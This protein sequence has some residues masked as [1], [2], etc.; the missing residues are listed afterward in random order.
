MTMVLGD[1]QDLYL[2]QR[3]QGNRL[4]YRPTAVAAN[5]RTPGNLLHQGPAADPRGHPRN[6]PWPAAQQRPGRTQEHP[7]AAAAEE[8]LRTAYRSIQQEADKT[9][10]ASSTCRGQDHRAGLRRHPR[11]SRDA[12]EHRVRRRKAHRLAG[13]RTHPNRARRVRPPWLGLR[14]DGYADPILHP[15]TRTRSRAGW[16]PPTTAPCNPATA[17]SCPTP[18]TTRSAPSASPS[19]AGASKSHDTQSMRS[20]TRPRCS[21]PS[22]KPCST[23]PAWRRRCARPSTPCRRRNAAGRG[24]PTTG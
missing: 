23:I 4:Y 20:T 15:P 17:L 8:R 1:N 5:P 19:L 6:P 2:E 3:R 12:A 18:G 24:R 9:L 13:H 22:C 21:S 7:P 16:V 10:T 14:L 11:D